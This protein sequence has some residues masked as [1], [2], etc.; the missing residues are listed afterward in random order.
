MACAVRPATEA[1]VP[2][3]LPMVRAI[4]E[5]HESADPQ[6][7]AALPDVVD[8]YARWLPARARDK[9]SV[10]LVGT[11][12][13]VGGLAGFLVA[14]V[15]EEIPIFRVRE[16]GWI[17]DVWVEPAARRSGLARALVRGAI[18][19]FAGMGVAQVRLDTGV[20]NDAARAAF[21]AEGFRPSVIEMLRP[22]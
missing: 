5:L 13:S 17:H 9:R 18:D 7:F 11:H 12:G 3:V 22:L 14:T 1:D 4:C 15:E 10:F 16:V 6:R 19:R 21:A 20:F 2:A 8:R